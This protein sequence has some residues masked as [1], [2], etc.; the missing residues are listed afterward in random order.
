VRWRDPRKQLEE[1]GADAESLDAMEARIEA[2]AATPGPH[3]LVLVA[4]GGA[5]V[6]SDQLHVRPSRSSGRVAALPHLLPYLAQRATDVPHV[7]VVADRTGADLLAVSGAGAA[8]ERSV[9]GG[10]Q[11]PIHRTGRDEWSERHFQNRVENTWESNA[12]DVAAEVTRLVREGSARLVVVA[13]DVRAR[14]LIADD[15]SSAL[16]AGV[17]VRSIDEG[18]RAAGSSTDALERAVHDQV[19]R[20]AWRQRREVLEHL[21]QN[22]GRHEYAVAGA[23]EVA[24][25]LQM[26]QVDTVVLSDDPSS[27]LR[28]WIGPQPTDF[29]LDDADTTALGLDPVEHDRYDAGLVRAVVGTGAK[30]LVTPGAHEYVADGIGA[31]L[32]F[33]TPQSH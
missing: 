9:E 22:L 19:L 25:A 5:L 6:Y 23:A 17:T 26:A 20:E 10:Q 1:D 18:G 3:G 11:H 31:L 13:G 30:L 7:V 14:N 15:L 27:T 2:D 21:Q 4:A 24:A 8:Q 29:G 16:G 32:R 33:D 12:K 28:A